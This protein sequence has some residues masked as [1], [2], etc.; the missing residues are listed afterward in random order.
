MLISKSAV[1]LIVRIAPEIVICAVV[2]SI[3]TTTESSAALYKVILPEPF[4]MFSLKVRVASLLIAT[5]V[6]LSVGLKVVI[7][8]ADG[9][10]N[11]LT[12]PE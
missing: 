9:I 4:T 6:A 10:E 2:T 5:L 11:T 7:V 8:G 12:C 3:V 1:G